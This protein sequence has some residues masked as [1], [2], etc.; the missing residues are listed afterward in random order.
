M[1]VDTLIVG[2]GIAGLNFVDQ[3]R[4]HKKSFVVMAPPT[5]QWGWGLG[6]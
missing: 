1:K 2:F 4:R 5:P 3:L 6:A